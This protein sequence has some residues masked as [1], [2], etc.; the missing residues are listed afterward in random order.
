MR[1][2]YSGLFY[3]A[4]PFILA[5]LSWRSIKAPAY[6]QRWAERFG[7]YAVPEDSGGIWFHA[8]S[9]GEAEAAFPLIR[10]LAERHPASPV[11]VTTT[12]PTG[13]ARV[14]AVLGDSVQHVYLPYDLPGSVERFLEHFKPHLAV[15]METEIWPNL[16]RACGDRRIPL[17]I[18]NARL[19]ERSARGYRR[20]PGLTRDCLSSVGLVAAQTQAD[21]DRF[22]QIGG[23]PET[24]CVTGNIKFDLNQ[25]EGWAEDAAQRRQLLFGGRP[26]LIAGSTHEGE[27]QPVLVAFAAA[28]Q[29][30]QDLALVIAPRHP[31]RFHAV[32]TLCGAQGFRVVRRSQG[33]PLGD[34]DVFLLDTLGELKQFYAVSDLAFVGG[35]LVPV[36]GHNVLEPASAGVPVL[37]GPHLFNFL[38]VSRCLLEAGGAVKIQDGRELGQAVIELLDAPHRRAQMGSQARQFVE[39]GRGALKRVAD[40]LESLLAETGRCSND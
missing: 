32:A 12:T 31:E 6:R 2:L 25:P 1:L 20:L 35:S 39:Q 21:A 28:R 36:G 4:V 34:A 10:L 14:R 23:K 8:V 3:L 9:V 30:F 16:F 13:S 26:V 15:V 27:D 22:I 11:L 29:Q 7:L 18:V 17:A 33:V 37:F 24:V 38:E 5:R 19:S 40:R